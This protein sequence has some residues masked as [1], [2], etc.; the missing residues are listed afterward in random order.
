MSA[1]LQQ[2]SKTT[3][4]PISLTPISGG[5][6]QRKCACGQHTISGGECNECSTD[7]GTASLR[8]SAVTDS[9]SDEI[10]PIM[11]EV[12]RSPGQPLDQ[13][14]RAFLEPRLGYDFSQVRVHTDATAAAS[15]LGVHALA[16]TVGR[17]VVFGSGQY[18]PHTS[19]GRRLL[20]H[21]L[22]HTIQ[23][24]AG[25]I[26]AGDRT[27]RRSLEEQATLHSDS[28]TLPAQ[29][30]VMPSAG[31]PPI[32]F[33]EDEYHGV[34]GWL[35]KEVYEPLQRDYSAW[36]AWGA[37]LSSRWGERIPLAGDLAGA[38]VGFIP[39]ALGGAGKII[40]YIPQFITPKTEEEA[41]LAVATFGMATPALNIGKAFKKG[42]RLTG[43]MKYG[44]LWL[45]NK[46][47]AKP[48]L[49]K[50]FEQQAPGLIEQVVEKV[51]QK[52]SA[53][54]K[55]LPAKEA[56]IGKAIGMAPESTRAIEAGNVAERVWG[57]VLVATQKNKKHYIVSFID[58]L[59]NEKRVV[60]VIPDFVPTGR[61]DAAGKYVTASDVKEAL[62]IADSKYTWDQEKRVAI[63]DQ[64]RAM[65]ALAKQA[66]KPFVFLLK[67][68]GDV[69][70]GVKKYAKALNV[71]YTIMRDVSGKVR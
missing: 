53:E 16:Y 27:N 31:A 9:V 58:P 21:E 29:H 23:Q 39:W 22:T 47:K 6:L 35:H 19:A 15:A 1:I 32:Q 54:L 7:R 64:V 63:S 14:A 10:P 12:L 65:L 71:E 18:S 66:G 33:Q 69:S 57:D 61:V 17:D 26:R 62:L 24:A 44:L 49:E 52:G 25:G 37:G 13:K 50:E 34:G 38:F 3:I 8:R 45:A 42:L 68:G 11:H 59:N 20:A 28:L 55:E 41:F 40:V 43:K 36:M 67:E 70:A 60:E 51:E 56:R 2:R 30:N 5:L 4:A 48:T 46:L